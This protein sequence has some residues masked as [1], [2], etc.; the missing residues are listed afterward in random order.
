MKAACARRDEWW[1]AEA[2]RGLPD[3]ILRGSERYSV[4][5]PRAP[6][7]SSA[8]GRIRAAKSARVGVENASGDAAWRRHRSASKA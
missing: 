3:P 1:M 6:N 2:S 8:H 5:A 7:S 4:R